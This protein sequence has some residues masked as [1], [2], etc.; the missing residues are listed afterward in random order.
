[1]SPNLTDYEERYIQTFFVSVKVVS[2]CLLFLFLDTCGHGKQ[3][4]IRKWKIVLQGCCE[5]VIGVWDQ[6]RNDLPSFS[7]WNL[8]NANLLYRFQQG[9][10]LGIFLFL[11]LLWFFRSPGF[12]HGW[13]IA[14]KDDYISDA[15]PAVL[16]AFLLFIWPSTNPFSQQN[17]TEEKTPY[18]PILTWK[19][20]TKKFPWDVVLLLGGALALADGV[21]VGVSTKLMIHSLKV[22]SVRGW[23]IQ[24]QK[25]LWTGKCTVEQCKF[26]RDLSWHQIFSFRLI[27]LCQKSRSLMFFDSAAQLST[28]FEESSAHY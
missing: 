24:N 6:W 15:T 8:V 11:V 1:M 22:T 13:D 2:S 16:M 14:F 26:E 27:S 28:S 20:T 23:E 5:A 4:A 17:G 7:V 10:S 9:S 12:M 18:R 19:E 3:T 25:S 21:Q